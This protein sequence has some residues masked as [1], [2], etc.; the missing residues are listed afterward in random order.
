M[1]LGHGLNVIVSGKAFY[2]A[3]TI[4]SLIADVVLIEPQ[5]NFW[6]TSAC[7]FFVII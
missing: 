3:D 5:T 4:V 1:C 6:R 7:N 2:K